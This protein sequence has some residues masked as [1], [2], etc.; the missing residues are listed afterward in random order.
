[1]VIPRRGRGRGQGRCWGAPWGAARALGGS[2]PLL[3]VHS[4]PLLLL[5][6]YVLNVRKETGRRKKKE[7]RKEKEG[8]E[9]KKIKKYGKF[10][11]LENF[12]GEK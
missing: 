9:K 6:V 7:R 10:S 11:K 8:K 2:T 4:L 5:S 3:L 12:Q 1:L